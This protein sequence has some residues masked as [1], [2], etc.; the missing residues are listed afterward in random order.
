MIPAGSNLRSVAII[1]LGA[2][3]PTVAALAASWGAEAMRDYPHACRQG[4]RPRRLRPRRTAHCIAQRVTSVALF[5][6]APVFVWMLATSGAPDPA[7]A[8]RLPRL[9]R[10]APSSPCSR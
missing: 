6:L 7:T 8:T 10:P 5:F 4:T 3:I 9:V 2:V 1:I